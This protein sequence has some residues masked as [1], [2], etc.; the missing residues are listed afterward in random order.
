[1]RRNVVRIIVLAGVAVLFAAPLLAG[2]GGTE[3][4]VASTGRGPGSQ[5]SE[6]YTTLWV[7][8][9]GTTSA[10]VQ[11]SFLLRNQANGA[12]PYVY[13]DSIPAGDTRRYDNAVFQM[14]GI[15]GFGAIR[16]VSDRTLIV[17]SRIYSTPAGGEEKDTVGQFFAGVPATFAIG[18]GSSTDVLGV[19]R[20]MPDSGSQ[21]R[22]NFGF[23]ETTGGTATV[24]VTVY[25]QAGASLGSKDYALGPYEVRQYGFGDEF[26][27]LSTTNARIKVAVLSGSGKVI[28]FGSGLANRSNDPS[29]FEMAFDSDLLASGLAAVAHDTTL[30]GDGTG[31]SPLGLADGAVSTA[32]I[33]DGAVT[34]QKVAVPLV[35]ATG[36]SKTL[37]LSN[38]NSGGLSGATFRAANTST[39]GAIAGIFVASG[40]DATLVVSGKGTGPLIKGF[41]ANG[42]EDEFRIDNNGTFHLFDPSFVETIRLDA[43]TGVATFKGISVTG[44]SNASLPIA[45]AFINAAGSTAAGTDNVSSSWDPA[46]E[47]YVITIAG[48][49]YF[50]QDYVTTVTPSNNPATGV[51][52]G[53]GGGKLLVYIYDAAGNAV[54]ADFQFVTYKP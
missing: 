4:F 16:L 13:N 12:T 3:V 53:S 2:F 30:A 41:G 29:T 22:Y 14:F 39:S 50:W 42:G 45:Y 23:V 36:A 43:P 54:Q 19:F 32:K 20:T 37:D 18:A 44:H 46:H 40:D 34:S 6:W 52:T 51:R 10:N 49:S 47:R 25:D 15:E 21:F 33:A 11:F 35:L 28:A 8:N 24:R 31:G 9:P 17:N 5:S 26:G 7:Y 38:N 1:M 48:E 27:A